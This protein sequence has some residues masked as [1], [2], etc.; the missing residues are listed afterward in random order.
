MV[1][2]TLFNLALCAAV[3]TAASPTV[4]LDNG[5]FTGTTDGVSTKFLGI[6]FAQ[7]P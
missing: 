2:K 7:P 3:A 4:K 1:T 6:P 5:V